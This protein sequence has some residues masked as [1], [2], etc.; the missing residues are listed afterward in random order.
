MW[1][2]TTISTR[3]CMPGWRRY[4]LILVDTW[5]NQLY[6]VFFEQKFAVT[7]STRIRNFLFI[8]KSRR[9]FHPWILSAVPKR[10]AILFFVSIFVSIPSIGKGKFVIEDWI[11]VFALIGLSRQSWRDTSVH[12]ATVNAK[13]QSLGNAR[14]FV[15]VTRYRNAGWCSVIRDTWNMMV[16]YEPRYKRR[17]RRSVS[18]NLPRGCLINHCTVDTREYGKTIFHPI[19]LSYTN[20]RASNLR[21]VRRYRSLLSSR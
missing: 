12:I 7:N 3:Y 11:I 18:F 13:F 6:R 5:Q 8:S 17:L 2:R 19:F 15:F 21:D 10:T 20:N 1:K 16:S 4:Y 14:C 9:A